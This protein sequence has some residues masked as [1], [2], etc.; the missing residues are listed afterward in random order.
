MERHGSRRA[1]A[2]RLV[3]G[4]MEIPELKGRLEHKLQSTTEL[5]IITAVML[6]QWVLPAFQRPLRVNA[7][8]LEVA[9]EILREGGIVPGMITL[10]VLNG[11]IYVV[12]GQ[13]RLHALRLAMD[14]GVKEGMAEV[15][16]CYFNSVGEMALEFKRLNSA[17]VKM[18]P[19]DKLR[20]MEGSCE[21]VATL[22]KLCPSVGYD[23]IRRGTS[24]AMISMSAAIRT[25]Y[26]AASDSLVAGGGGSAEAMALKM[27][28][29]QAREWAT[30]MNI[31]TEAWGFDAPYR[32]LYATLNLA[33]CGWLYF[34]LVRGKDRDRASYARVKAM[35]EDDFSACLAGLS[36]NT[37][38][39][40]WLVNRNLTEHDRGP[41]Y[42]RVTQDFKNTMLTNTGKKIM[43]PSPEWFAQNGR[44]VKS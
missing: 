6:T 26:A 15:R 35:D 34:R 42:K 9:Q 5:R 14:A 32:R 10:G 40:A 17:L 16:V 24:G 33:T 29:T 31:A 8:V 20:A 36:A 22:R 28:A 21:S 1:K 13:H 44:P 4:G 12:D 30:F 41:C 39:L 27:T 3:V 2:L 25:A 19:D 38:Y 37:K 23:N 18:R 43:L 11:V 7:A